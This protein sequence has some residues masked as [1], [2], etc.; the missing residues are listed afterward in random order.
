MSQPAYR[1]RVHVRPQ[2]EL[3]RLRED[4]GP[5]VVDELTDRIAVA[6]EHRQPS[7]AQKVKHAQGFDDL[8]IARGDGVRAVCRLAKPEFQVLLVDKR[9]TVY[10]RLDVA[11]QRAEEGAAA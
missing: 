9:R 6:S 4:H 3:D 7:T 2:H 5:D 10:D 8:L 11:A 1:I